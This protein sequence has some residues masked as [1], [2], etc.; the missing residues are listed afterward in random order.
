[1]KLSVLWE[2]KWNEIEGVAL[3]SFFGAVMAFLTVAFWDVIAGKMMLQHKSGYGWQQIMVLA[4]LGLYIVWAW[5]ISSKW[6][7]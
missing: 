4:V 7:E 2:V 5:M 1:M 3:V 6:G